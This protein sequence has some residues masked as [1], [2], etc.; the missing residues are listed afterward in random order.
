[1]YVGIKNTREQCDVSRP[2]DYLEKTNNTF[3]SGLEE[4]VRQNLYLTEWAPECCLNIKL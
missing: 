2:L 1:M 3:E 4:Y